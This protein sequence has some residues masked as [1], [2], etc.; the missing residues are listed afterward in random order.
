MRKIFRFAVVMLLLFAVGCEGIRYSHVAPEA[1]NFHPQRLGVLPANVGTYEDARGVIDKIVA[2]VLVDTKWFT[3][4]APAAEM[5]NRL[6]S[7]GTLKKVYTD[8]I[9]KL[10]AVNYSDPE[11]SRRFGQM[12]RVDAFLLVEVDYWNYTTEKGDKVGKVGMGMKMIDAAS[13]G[14]MWK[15]GHY[16]A[17]DYLIIKPALPDVAKSLV[18]KM[19]REMPH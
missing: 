7:D 11:L 5:N 8:Y 17:Q 15:A 6:Q 19:I 10:N 16:E 13:G 9:A 2:D 18:K 14:I 4:V 3:D 12:A 1:K